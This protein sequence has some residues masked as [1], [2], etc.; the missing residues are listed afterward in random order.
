MGWSIV[1][2]MSIYVCMC[3]HRLDLVNISIVLM[4]PSSLPVTANDIMNDFKP[5]NNNDIIVTNKLNRICHYLPS[6]RRRR[7]KRTQ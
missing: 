3:A 6:D 2:E 4:L 5:N 1:D 7:K